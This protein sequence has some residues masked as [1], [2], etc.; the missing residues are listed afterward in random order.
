MTVD[1]RAVLASLAALPVAAILPRAAS[2]QEI[3]VRGQTIRLSKRDK[4]ALQKAYARRG[5][6]GVQ[7]MCRRLGQRSSRT[8][9]ARP[10]APRRGPLGARLPRG[11]IRHAIDIS[12]GCRVTD[13]PPVRHIAQ[14]IR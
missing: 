1:R 3:T 6:A 13:A 12:Q 2:A 7:R 4:A 8:T 10:L 5:H 11:Q 14:C 9:R